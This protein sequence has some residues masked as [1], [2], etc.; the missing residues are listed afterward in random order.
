MVALPD[1]TS[2][3]VEET[4][5][6][7]KS[8]RKAAPGLE[9]ILGCSSFVPKGG[10]PF[11][12][13]VRPDNKTVEGRFKILQR[14][15]DKVCDV[16]ATSPKWDFFQAFL[17]RGDR[18]LSKLLVRFYHHGGSLGHIKRAL[19]E[20]KEEGQMDFPELDWYAL[21]ERPE[22]EILPWDMITLGV[23]RDILYKESLPSP[24][25][26]KEYGPQANSPDSCEHAE[27]VCN[28]HLAGAV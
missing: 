9:I 14:G 4:V 2:D 20:L 18:R 5:Q 11:Q 3:D 26:L 17:S 13:Q 25:Y 23:P 24:G 8:V 19:K 1:E 27:T 6:L 16:R 12:W 21:R 22:S 7:M 15:L 28:N 10:T